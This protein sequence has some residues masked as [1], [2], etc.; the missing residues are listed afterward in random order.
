MRLKSDEQRVLAGDIDDLSADRLQSIRRKF[1]T[2]GL[3]NANGSLSSRGE[4]VAK[5]LNL[6]RS[7]D[8]AISG[9]VGSKLGRQ[10]GSSGRSRNSG[11]ASDRTDKSGIR[12]DVET[13]GRSYDFGVSDAPDLSGADQSEGSETD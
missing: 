6:V 2:F 3:L 8:A 7:T 11:K 10:S 5:T 9:Q 1:L 4:H 13:S 12:S